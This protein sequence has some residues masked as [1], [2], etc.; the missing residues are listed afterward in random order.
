M[1]ILEDI[2]LCIHIKTSFPCLILCINKVYSDPVT[3]TVLLVLNDYLNYS[4]GNDSTIII[5]GEVKFKNGIRD[6]EALRVLQIQHNTST[7]DMYVWVKVC[8]S[9]IKCCT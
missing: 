2:S 3:D 5:Q 1:A 7:E 9:L 8:T 6:V 4:M